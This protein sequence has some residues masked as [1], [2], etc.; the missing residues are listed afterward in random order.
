MEKEK[1]GSG[2][3]TVARNSVKLTI[4]AVRCIQAFDESGLDAKGILAL[5]AT[6]DL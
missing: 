5:L 4:A 1:P 3:G 6:F 2:S